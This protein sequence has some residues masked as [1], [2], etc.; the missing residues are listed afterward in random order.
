MFDRR[1]DRE[2]LFPLPDLAARRTI[3]GIHS[4]AW[5][6]QP[7]PVLLDELARL[8]G[9]YCGADIKVRAYVCLACCVVWCTLLLRH[10][11]QCLE[12]TARTCA[13]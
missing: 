1:F 10:P 13:A 2:L 12:P 11:Q 3:L 6:P 4:R 8:T 9:G 5:S 7:T